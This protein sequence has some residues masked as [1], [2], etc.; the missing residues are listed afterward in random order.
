[1]KRLFDL[2]AAA[3]G[4]AW[5]SPLLLAVAWAIHRQ[6]GGPVFYRGR[7]VGL[8]GADFRIFK[9][10]TMVVDAERLGGPSTPDDDP[11]ITPL[12]A[13]LRKYK[14][15][16]LPQ[17]LNV[18][19]GE[20][21][22]VGPRPEVRR[23]TDM[24]TPEERAILGVRPGITDWASIWNPDEGSILAGAPDPE[25]AYLQLI[26]PTKVRLQLKYVREQSLGT[27]LRILRD[28]LAVL[29][30]P[31]ARERAVAALAAGQTP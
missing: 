20:M 16:E 25:A 22:L 30:S 17:L 29:V 28:T 14:L 6:D 15:D 10:R 7:R 11:R 2:M 21:S 18:F 4:L 31:G 24:F 19:I 26:R 1:M 12:G 27:D 9:F 23:Y 3:L 8:N 13:W 5:L